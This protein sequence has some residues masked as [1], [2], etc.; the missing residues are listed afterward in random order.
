VQR[1]FGSGIAP[2]DGGKERPLSEAQLKQLEAWLRL[3][4]EGWTRNV[5]PPVSASYMVQVEHSDSTMTFV[6]LFSCIHSAIYFSK[7]NAGRFDAG[8][9]H[10]PA[11]EVEALI[12]MLREK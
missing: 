10:S 11:A 9:L 6:Y 8:W 7:F 5:I 12:A 3:H 4:R 2:G 1:V